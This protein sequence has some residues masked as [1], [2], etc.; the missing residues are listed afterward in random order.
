MMAE[1]QGLSAGGPAAGNFGIAGLGSDINMGSSSLLSGQGAVAGRG[2]VGYLGPGL[3][4]NQSGTDGGVTV[5]GQGAGDGGSPTVGQKQDGA[6]RER[7]VGA[8]W[9]AAVMGRGEDGEPLSPRN[10]EYR[11]KMIEMDAEHK[12]RGL[13]G[14]VVIGRDGRGSA[15]RGLR[16]TPPYPPE[17][18]RW[19]PGRT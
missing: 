12:V 3:H 14:L 19:L 2:G 4:G 1:I 13:V 11:R 6:A 15:G 10:R 5:A 17:G 8:D 18:S 9:D 16:N 7:G